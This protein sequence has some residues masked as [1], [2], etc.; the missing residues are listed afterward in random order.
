MIDLIKILLSPLLIIYSIVVRIRNRLFD[1]GYF[2]SERIG[3]KVISIGNLTV[4][5]S[6]KTPTVIYISNMLKKMG[7]RVG[8]MSRGYGRKSK[9]YL[10]V[11]D[12]NKVLHDVRET[13]DEIFLV[14]EECGIPAAVSEKRVHGAKRF[15]KDVDLD[16]IVLDDAFQHRWIYRD[17]NILMFDQRFLVKQSGRNRKLL[18]L[19]E[20]REPFSAVDRSDIIII[21]RKFSEKIELPSKIEEM[22]IGKEVFYGHYEAE[23]FY[24]VKDHHFYPFEE[25]GGQ[26]SLIVCGIARPYSFL[27]ILENNG[28][29][30]TNKLLT[31]DHKDYSLKEVQKIRKQFYDTNANSVITT[32]K[33]A[34][35]L[36]SFAKELDDIDIYYLKINLV[37]E[38]EEMLERKI[39]TL[40]N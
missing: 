2:S 6:G 18:P 33:D 19:G 9:G 24:D 16:V 37:I 36:N 1:R 11:N 21:N 29:D 15:L 28:I 20:M 34:V 27:H 32:Q 31:S 38:N 22:F 12:G 17:I 39:L 8:V 35:K 5:G 3:A 30:F 13:G 25:F 26:K 10:L 40:F 23:G 4:G 14:S 7:K